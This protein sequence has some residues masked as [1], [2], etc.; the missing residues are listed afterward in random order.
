MRGQRIVWA[1]LLSAAAHVSAAHGQDVQNG[2]AIFETC[3]ACHDT[4]GPGPTLNGV[5]QRKIGAVE[6]FEYSEALAQANNKAQIW[7]D[8]ALEKFLTAPQTYLPDN[9]MAFGAVTDA[10]DRK[11]VIAYLKTLQ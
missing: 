11:D 8:D 6:G 1:V 2:R 10:K 9:K 5:Y 3:L 7:D 4:A